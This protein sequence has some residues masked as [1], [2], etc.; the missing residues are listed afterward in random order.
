MTPVQCARTVWQHEGV[1]NA[2][3]SSFVP[4]VRSA[5]LPP[6]WRARSLSRCRPCAWPSRS[7]PA[8]LL[9]A[10]PI[11]GARCAANGALCNN[12]DSG[13]S[14]FRHGHQRSL[15]TRAALCRTASKP[16]S[17]HIQGR[18]IQR[19]FLFP[20]AGWLAECNAPRP[21]FPSNPIRSTAHRDTGSEQYASGDLPRQRQLELEL[22]ADPERRHWSIERPLLSA[23]CDLRLLRSAGC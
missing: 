7:P 9:S 5:P 16:L 14:P 22:A 6:E 18:A 23:D 19:R 21:V 20:R 8:D 17:T 11:D 10:L 15:L 12:S 3:A 4:S 13:A 1:A 2:S